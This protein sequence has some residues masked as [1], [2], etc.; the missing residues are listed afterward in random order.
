MKVEKE[1]RGHLGIDHLIESGWD[2]GE[3]EA[4]LDGLF[5]S[6]AHKSR[7]ELDIG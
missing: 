7:H 4:F 3:Q 1:L 2:S 5:E 6:I